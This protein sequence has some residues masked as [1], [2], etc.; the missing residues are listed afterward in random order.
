MKKTKADDKPFLISE[1]YILQ[2]QYCLN[3]KLLCN[4]LLAVHFAM[5]TTANDNHEK[6][7]C[8]GDGNMV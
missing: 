2:R 5:V 8:E 3:F 4:R 1:I 6:S 7:P